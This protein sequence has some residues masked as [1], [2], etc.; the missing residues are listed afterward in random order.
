MFRYMFKR[1]TKWNCWSLPHI[2]GSRDYSGWIMINN[3]ITHIREKTI[4]VTQDLIEFWKVKVNTERKLKFKTETEQ[5]KTVLN[6]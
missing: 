1:K 6:K 3:T 5:I 2:F 4:N